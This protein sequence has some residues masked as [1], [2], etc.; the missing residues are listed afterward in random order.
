M[1]SLNPNNNQ[2]MST[3]N[4]LKGFT[5]ETHLDRENAEHALWIDLPSVILITGPHGSGKTTLAQRIC[6]ANGLSQFFLFERMDQRGYQIIRRSGRPVVFDNVKSRQINSNEFL[7]FLSESKYVERRLGTTRSRSI[8]GFNPLVII[9]A[10]I[11]EVSLDAARRCSLIIRLGS[12][13]QK[14]SAKRKASSVKKGG[15][16]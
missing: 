15:S 2:T 7:S 4:I 9:T 5:F 14:A 11:E 10:A 3:E 13:S 16:K 8:G 6:Q 1:I 12:R